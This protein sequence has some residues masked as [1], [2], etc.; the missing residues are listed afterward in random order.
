MKKA[1]LVALSS[2][3]AIS[4]P[5]CFLCGATESLPQFFFYFVSSDF[6]HLLTHMRFEGFEKLVDQITL[7]I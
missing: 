1:E 7:N 6:Q 3:F 5:T 2:D 4:L